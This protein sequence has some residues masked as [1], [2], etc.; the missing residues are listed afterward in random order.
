[1]KS[2]P[3]DRDVGRQVGRNDFVVNDTDHCADDYALDENVH[4]FRVKSECLVIYWSTRIDRGPFRGLY[5]KIVPVSQL[6]KIIR[7]FQ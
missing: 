3:L 2:A 5:S 4:C 1:M 7:S 6:R